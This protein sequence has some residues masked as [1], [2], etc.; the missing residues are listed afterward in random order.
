YLTKPVRQSQLFDCLIQ[1]L[2]TRE[3]TAQEQLE[4]LTDKEGAETS[5][6]AQ[7]LLAED[8]PVNQVVALEMLELMGCQVDLAENGQEALA[9][10][11]QKDYDLVF[12]DCQM[13]EMDGFEA[14]REIRRR[15]QDTKTNRPITIIALT[16]NAMQGDRE[17]CLAAGMDDFVSKPFALEQLRS[18]LQRWLQTPYPAKDAMVEGGAEDKATQI[19]GKTT[20]DKVALDN[21]RRLQRPGKPDIL[22]KVIGYY[23]DSAPRLLE[24]LHESLARKDAD[25]LRMAAHSLKSSSA[26]LGAK[27]LAGD[28]LELETM[29]R[30]NQLDGA[31][32]ILCRLETNFEQIRAELESYPGI[33]NALI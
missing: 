25:A 15:E 11:S 21:I 31:A 19:M 24:N 33:V 9:A 5:L 12:M 30:N 28:C 20:L 1:V 18:V 26:N 32:G 13:P 17:R 27:A 22:Q 2:G 23:M 14:T 6:E 29:A 16:A 8:N 3:I 10:L 7:L 4:I